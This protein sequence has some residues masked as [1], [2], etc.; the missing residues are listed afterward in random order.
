MIMILGFISGSAH[1]VMNLYFGKRRR[2][3]LGTWPSLWRRDADFWTVL[4]EL[5][6]AVNEVNSVNLVRCQHRQHRQHRQKNRRR[7]AAWPFALGE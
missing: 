5:T 4:T 1:L 7:Q 2:P 3:H 6:V